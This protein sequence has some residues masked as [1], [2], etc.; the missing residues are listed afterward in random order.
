KWLE[1]AVVACLFLFAFCAPH[2][3][4]ATQAFWLL[5]MLFWVARFLA[6]PRPRLR[7]TPVDYALLGFFILT[8]I[9]ALC[10]YE[11]I[12]SIGKLRAASLF[13]IVYV[14][15]EN[16]SDRRTA[17]RLVLVLL[18][19][20]MLNVIYTFGVFA[21]GRGF[22]IEGLKPESVLYQAGVREGDTILEVAGGRRLRGIEDL[23]DTL[24]SGD[25]G[26]IKGLTVQVR[27]YRLESYPVFEVERGRLLAGD[28]PETR[29]GIARWSHGRD[30]RA[31]GFYGHYVTYAEVL[32]LV[33]SLAL[34]MFV[35]VRRRWSWRGV[36]LAASVV[37][38]AGALMLTLTRAAWLGMLLSAFV[39]VL[40]G[41]SRRMLLIAVAVALPLVVAG[42]LV[43]QAKRQVGFID[44]KEGSTA[45]RLMVYRESLSLLVREPRH[46]AVGVGMDSLKR[47]YREWGLFDNGR[48]N[49]GHLHS[50][51]LQLAV[52]RGL[53][54]LCAWLAL[55]LFYGRT[56]WRLAR[57]GALDDWIERGLVLGALGGLVGFLA[58]G[59]VHYNLGD[60]EVA[61]VFYFI[62]GLALVV[63]RCARATD[64][65]QEKCRDGHT[66]GG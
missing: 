41:A 19:S 37:G 20:C 26:G 49:I 7:R 31:H 22:R 9:S 48:Q 52:E 18:A 15:A 32:Q 56:L 4:A 39:I 64:G 51:P 21:V 24:A 55:V 12:V 62:M 45:W 46:L 13:T 38:L 42:L 30:E 8:F 16:V 14:V 63:E 60:S 54:T 3:I 40:A 29:L 33:A 10:S 65:A 35:A 58:S 44:A 1:R 50:T 43:L 59:M 61:E 25:A 17:R 53:P 36:L 47:H 5:A 27:V 57:R 28:T 6:R 23:S 11:P 34:G 66:G 2:S